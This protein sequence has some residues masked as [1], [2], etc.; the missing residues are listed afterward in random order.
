MALVVDFEPIQTRIWDWLNQALN[1]GA[2]ENSSGAIPI[3]RAEGDAVRPQEGIAFVDFKFLTGL[4]K[5]G[6]ADELLPKS[7]DP[8]NGILRGQRSFTVSVTAYGAKAPEMVAQIQQ[9]LS[10]PIECDILRGG[11]LSVFNDEAIT[12]ASIF[13]ETAFENRAVLDVTFGF[14]LELEVAVGPIESIEVTAN[15]P[16]GKKSTIDKNTGISVSEP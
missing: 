14:A 4:V 8:I 11:G 5:T 9:S 13:Q 7:G 6:M 10:S 1:Q 2:A 3:L 15:M 12:D 16:G